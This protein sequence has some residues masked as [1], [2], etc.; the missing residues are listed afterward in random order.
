MSSKQDDIILRLLLGDGDAVGVVI[1]DGLGCGPVP[2]QLSQL[3][4]LLEMIRIAPPSCEELGE[5]DR[6]VEVV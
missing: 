4:N 6:P 1:E 5:Q 3:N 2:K